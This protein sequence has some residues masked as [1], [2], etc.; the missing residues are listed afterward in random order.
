MKG[1]SPLCAFLLGLLLLSSC[2]NRGKPQ[3]SAE[4]ALARAYEYGPLLLTLAGRPCI[5]MRDSVPPR[6]AELADYRDRLSSAHGWVHLGRPIQMECVFRAYSLPKLRQFAAAGDVVARFALVLRQ[7]L[8]DA[9]YCRRKDEYER[10]FADIGDTPT[11]AGEA[12]GMRYRLPDAFYAAARM[13]NACRSSGAESFKARAHERG[14]QY[15]MT[16]LPR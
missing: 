13:E 16:S 2:S 10:E 6:V 4:E 5:P 7:A 8:V 1:K 15:D 3:V 12:A 9:D 11:E 14:F